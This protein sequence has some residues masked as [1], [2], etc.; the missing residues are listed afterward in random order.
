[1]WSDTVR[2][3]LVDGLASVRQPMKDLT[4]IR[5]DMAAVEASRGSVPHL[6]V[7]RHVRAVIRCMLGLLRSRIQQTILLK[8]KCNSNCEKRGHLRSLPFVYT[9]KR[10]T[11]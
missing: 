10:I 6:Q 8:Q 7:P 5:M 4:V 2:H 11:P 9:W 1:M 3:S